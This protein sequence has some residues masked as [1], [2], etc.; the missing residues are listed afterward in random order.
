MSNY[1]DSLRFRRKAPKAVSHRFRLLYDKESRDCYVF[2]EGDLDRD[3]YLPAIEGV[4]PQGSRIH[5]F[6]CDGKAG[7]LDARETILQEQRTVRRCLFFVDKDHDD[8]IG[9]PLPKRKNLFVT[10][11]YSVENYVV[12]SQHL[13]IIMQKYFR[14]DAE[15]P[16]FRK[17]LATFD[18][19]Y[20]RFVDKATPLMAWVLW[21]RKNGNLPIMNNANAN[22]C[23]GFSRSGKFFKRTNAYDVYRTACGLAGCRPTFPELRAEVSCLCR[24]EHKKFVRGKMDL[25]FMVKF[26]EK[27]KVLY[28][29]YKKIDGRKIKTTTTC[30]LENFVQ[31]LI[32]LINYPQNLTSFILRGLA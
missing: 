32:G 14:L 17:I 21:A 18:S 31:L 26:I 20:K 6:L 7:V 24:I 1:L 30:T 13:Q 10:R 23:F 27:I 8:I 28:S 3:Y 9:V 5:V 12:D 16:L 22:K 25:W 19:E 15:D 29:K 4:M 2:I 11:W